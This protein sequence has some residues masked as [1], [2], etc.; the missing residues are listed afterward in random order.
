MKH[1]ELVLHLRGFA[2]PLTYQIATDERQRWIDAHKAKSDGF[3]E[4]RTTD[5]FHLFIN[6]A[7]VPISRLLNDQM[8]DVP[9]DYDSA[10]SRRK[11]KDSETGEFSQERWTFRF[12]II[13]LA[14]PIEIQELDEHDFVTISCS[15]LND[16]AFVSVIDE[17]H[18][19]VFFR[20]ADILLA[21]GFDHHNYSHST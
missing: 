12:W 4:Y 19:P 17:D 5:H 2:E 14:E 1:S 13:G 3:G 9:D 10:W 11:S 18:E 15:L 6:H 7:S 16:K 8:L 21:E 20:V